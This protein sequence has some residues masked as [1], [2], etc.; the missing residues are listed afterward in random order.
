V[1]RGGPRA[2]GKRTAAASA[3]TS[4]S[5]INFPMLEVSGCF[6]QRLPK[7]VA[8]V[9]VIAL[10]NTARVRLDCNSFVSPARHPK[11]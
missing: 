2:S 5:A 7:A 10:K 9:I 3:E 6:E 4:D 11:T 8:V 1:A